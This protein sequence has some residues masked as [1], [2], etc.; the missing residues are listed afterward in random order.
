MSF[1]IDNLPYGA[2]VTAEGRRFAAVRFGDAVLDLARIDADLFAGGGLDEF[3]AAGPGAWLR[4]RADV[5]DAITADRYPLV[6][7]AEVT[8]VLAFTIGDYVD[9]FASEHHAANAGRIFRPGNDNPLSANWKH[10]PIGYDGRAG[11]IV[12]SGTGIVR[13]SGQYPGDDGAVVFAPTRRLDLEAEV[14][15]VV[16]T[17]GSHIPVADADEHVFG[18]CLLNDWSARDVQGFESAPLGPF[19]GKSFATSLAAWITPLDAL[20]GSRTSVPQE[21][22]PLP[23]LRE[24]GSHGLR[25]DLE[26]SIN[27]HVVARPDFGAMYWSYAQMLAHLTSNGS[28]VR[29]GDVFASG[30]VSGPERGQRGCLLELTW[31][32]SEPIELGDGATRTWLEDGDD[33]VVTARAGDISLGEV[34]GRVESG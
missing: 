28:A 29:T 7:L 31:N 19:L 2:V 10:Q 14:A 8:P 26:V 12:V 27:G 17:P 24:T 34:A 1:G 6:P 15:F 9:F 4:V 21:P 18:I 11:S 23:H 25:L 32:G 5:V 30:T 33:V 22:E 20:D 3:L 13:P 16:G